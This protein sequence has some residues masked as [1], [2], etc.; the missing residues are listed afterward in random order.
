MKIV[1]NYVHLGC[2][3]AYS[4]RIEHLQEHKEHFSHCFGRCVVAIK[5]LL[6]GMRGMLIVHLDEIKKAEEKHNQYHFS[7]LLRKIEQKK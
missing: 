6:F 1:D 7:I 2:R 4:Y 3:A 5:T